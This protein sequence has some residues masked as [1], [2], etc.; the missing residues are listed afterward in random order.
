MK[1]TAIVLGSKEL[2]HNIVCQCK[3]IDTS[4][5]EIA[6]ENLKNDNLNIS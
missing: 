4:F 3:M 2:L 6:F 5:Y 1:K